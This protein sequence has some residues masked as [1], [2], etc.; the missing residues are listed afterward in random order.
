[1]RV[2]IE[3]A[4]LS[5]SSG[6]L[7]RYTSELSLA[8]AR[9][10]PDDEFFLISDQAF[11]HAGPRARQSEMRRRSAQCDGAPLVALGAGARDGPAG[12]RPG[13]RTRFR[14]ALSPAAAQR[15]H[16]ARSLAVDGPALASRR[17]S[18][19]P[20]HSGAVRTRPRH[21]GDHSRR[22]GA[23]RGH[24]AL[25]PA[26]GSRGGGA[27]S[28]GSLV[29]SAWRPRRRRPTSSSWARWSRA[30][31]SR[32]CWKPG[33]KCA[34]ITR[35]TWCSP[36]AAAP[37]LPKFIRSPACAL[38]GE[39][40]DS[41]LPALYSGA[42][43]F[44]YPSLYEG[45][46]LPVL[47]AMQCGAPVI[48]SRAVEEAAGDAAIYADTP[49]ELARRWRPGVAP[50]TRG[51]HAPAFPGARPRILLGTD[52]PADPSGLRGGKGPLWSVSL[53]M[54]PLPTVA[55]RCPSSRAQDPVRERSP[56]ATHAT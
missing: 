13:P 44:V 34:A 24:R 53:S 47:E 51:R 52:R 9:C 50:R 42:L 55:A 29:P 16:P 35:W 45:F 8:L 32:C 48:A 18:R 12:R 4:S 6:G 25:P 33:A 40:A 7:A 31:I 22:E 28:R 23:A 11:P 49:R 36:G 21:H 41:E 56:S 37:T 54:Q 27:G 20:A 1:M 30:R 17:P 2:A 10:F 26:A 3:A 15:A 5:L 43:A 38:A 46:G 39:V 14:R 19:P